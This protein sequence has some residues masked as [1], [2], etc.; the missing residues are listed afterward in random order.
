V[1]HALPENIAENVMSAV[2][3]LWSAAH[4]EAES[5][6]SQRLNVVRQHLDTTLAERSEALAE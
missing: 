1:P 2:N 4:E 3:R 6:A 5:A